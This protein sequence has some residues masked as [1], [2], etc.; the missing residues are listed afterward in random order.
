MLFCSFI[1]AAVWLA[2][3][4]LRADGS[5]ASL[6]SSVPQAIRSLGYLAVCTCVLMLLFT[7]LDRFLESRR[8]IA[9]SKKGVFSLYRRHP[10]A[11]P[12]AALLLCWS[13][14]LILAYPGSFCND[15]LVQ[16][17]Q[18][19]HYNKFTSHHPPEHSLLIGVF[20]KAGM[21]LGSANIG[22]FLHIMMQAVL[23]A[24]TL[25]YLLYFMR[26]LQS[27]RWLRALT[28]L[29]AALSPYY[30][31]YITLVVKDN[32][33]SYAILLFVIELAYLL[34]LKE[35]FFR[36]RRH[37]LLLGISI[38]LAVLIRNNGMYVIYPTVFVMLVVTFFYLKR[39]NF[40]RALLVFVVPILLAGGAHAAVMNHFDIQKGSIRE[41]L[42]LPF[43]QTARY[44]K[45]YPN[46]VTPQEEKR[47]NKVLK[48]DTLAENYDPRISDPVKNTYR[49][50]VSKTDL[51]NYLKVW[52]KQ[53][54]KHPVV[55]LEATLHQNYSLLY[56]V[57]NMKLYDETFFSN[58][59]FA[60]LYEKTGLHEVPAIDRL[61]EYRTA[62]NNALAHFPLTGLFCNIAVCNIVLLALCCY[63]IRRK[64]FLF[65]LTALPVLLSDAIVVLAPVI[66]GHPRYALPI[67]YS[68]PLLL[69][70]YLS[71]RPS[72][73]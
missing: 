61:D 25:S 11:L 9:S 19:F 8:D 20:I 56:P 28:F 47:I 68:M 15:S 23:F 69:A 22:L 33:Y 52:V 10:F 38:I 35:A 65:L 66:Q 1:I 40:L 55:Y 34:R 73:T 14:Q 24:L 32:L 18:V 63:A 57:V 2:A 13:W 36:S 21:W 58:K 70:F 7:L 39:K 48:Y 72:S 29:T 71:L 54:L 51:L 3:R 17:L 64:R 50:S 27:P 43:Q 16:L 49:K 41:A 5:L 46:E 60:D 4:G 62:F 31:E 12:F 37:V 6:F 26:E 67:V 53:G 42:S 45:E 59:R 44:V 30:T